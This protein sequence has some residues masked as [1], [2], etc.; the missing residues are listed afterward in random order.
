MIG[1][2]VA[3]PCFEQLFLR[4]AKIKEN[5]VLGYVWRVLKAQLQSVLNDGKALD[6]DG[7]NLAVLR[8]EYEML[9]TK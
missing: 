8:E 9:A 7:A 1:A 5:D 2:G 6:S 3:A 4:A